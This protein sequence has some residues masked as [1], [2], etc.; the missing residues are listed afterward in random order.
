MRPSFDLSPFISISVSES[1]TRQMAMSAA[2]K[3]LAVTIPLP[4]A[5]GLSTIL[6]DSSPST[7]FLPSQ[8][9][10]E[11]L[12]GVAAWLDDT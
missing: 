5:D 1:G 11:L 2:A 7:P 3:G 10:N 4:P 6:M 12:I 8:S 9:M